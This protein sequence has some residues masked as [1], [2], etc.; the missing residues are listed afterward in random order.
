MGVISL[1]SIYSLWKK[2]ADS[3]SNNRVQTDTKIVDSIPA[4]SNTIGNVKIDSNGNI[5][6]ANINT[7]IPA[8][9]NV[10]GK[11][12]IDETNNGVEIIGNNMELYGT[13]ISNAPSADS[14]PVGTVF[15]VVASTPEIYQSNG[16]DWVRWD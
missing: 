10:I 9:T 8:G 1:G 5:V 14:V 3:V 16:A 15:M 12:G 6:R 7:S 11:V 13:S 4:G 2:L